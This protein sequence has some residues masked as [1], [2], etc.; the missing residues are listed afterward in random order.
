MKPKISVTINWS[1]V[2]AGVA[3]ILGLW[4][5]AIVHTV[6]RD[7]VLH[8]DW[9]EALGVLI[10]F[11]ALVIAWHCLVLLGRVLYWRVLRPQTN[12]HP[13]PA[14]AD[15]RPQLRSGPTSR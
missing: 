13:A 2:L 5:Y 14:P 11:A 1:S 3:G 8:H 10:F 12:A 9:L 15:Q 4:V 6:I 7:G